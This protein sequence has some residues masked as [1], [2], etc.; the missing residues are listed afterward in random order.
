MKKKHIFPYSLLEVTPSPSALEVYD[1]PNISPPHID[2]IEEDIWIYVFEEKHFSYSLQKFSSNSLNFVHSLPMTVSE[3]V[4]EFDFSIYNNVSGVKISNT[5]DI[6]EIISD[7]KSYLFT[8]IN[9]EL[10][11]NSYR[12]TCTEN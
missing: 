4:E 12:I 5:T 10:P 1:I 8:L 2:D 3:T 7:Y 9:L 11:V 6:M